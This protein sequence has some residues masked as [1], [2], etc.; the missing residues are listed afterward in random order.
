MRT[1][2][3]ILKEI[4]DAAIAM[5][6]LYNRVNDASRDV[7]I[8]KA[9]E[10][11]ERLSKRSSELQRELAEL[12]LPAARAAMPGGSAP[13]AT[14]DALLKAAE[15]MRAIQIGT[16]T[17]SI[18]AINQVRELFK[19]IAETDTILNLASY[20]Y[21][22][23]AATNIP[24][25]APMDEPKDY[26][27]AAESVEKD[28][29]A[30]IYITE[31]QPKA[32][33]IVLPVSAEMIAMGSVDIESELPSIFAKAFTTVMHKGM[34]TGSGTGKLMKGIFTSAADNTN[35]DAKVT[36]T[37]SGKITV[38]ELAELAL[39]IASLD[40]SF[41]I[42]M[43]PAVYQGIL[44]STSNDSEDIKVYKEGLIRDKSIEGVPILLDACAPTKDSSNKA[45]AVAVPLSRYAI[46][47]AAELKIEPIRKVYDTQTYYQ[48]I[49]FFSGKQV[50][51][52]D[53]YSVVSG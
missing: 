15:E 42:I 16:G 6:S 31:I 33:A 41:R 29:G 34:L 4:G 45:I 1:E 39:K 13:I 2:T 38:T 48:A 52:K 20:Y 46:G 44:S 23:N 40:T 30:S 22:P 35:A 43:N 8:G 24:V 7:D 9:T 53:V 21:G 50:T 14:R 17:P 19:E 47:V 36:G 51:D 3:A 28:T 49:M 37:T 18:G 25:L 10:E 12:R 32:H 27:E 5:R 11:L 26:D